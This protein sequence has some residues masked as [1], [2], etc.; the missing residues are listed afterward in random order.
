MRDTLKTIYLFYAALKLVGRLKNRF[1]GARHNGVY[2]K[3]IVKEREKN[4]T[5]QAHVA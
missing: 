1:L 3:E 2:D 5:G 4:N